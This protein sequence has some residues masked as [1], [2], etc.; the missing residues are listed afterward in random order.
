MD[1]FATSSGLFV[2]ILE[3][4]KNKKMNQERKFLCEKNKHSIKIECCF[5]FFF[6]FFFLLLLQFQ[7]QKIRIMM[8]SSSIKCKQK[9][10]CYYYWVVWFLGFRKKKNSTKRIFSMKKTPSFS[11]CWVFL[12]LCCFCNCKRR[13]T[14]DAGFL[15]SSEILGHFFFVNVEKSRVW[16]F[17]Y[18]LC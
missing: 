12:C 1:R 10:C 5:F 17:M 6:F 16:N 14:Q 13:R 4:R 15:T 18:F 2:W 11:G 7:Q 8:S 9:F 3:L